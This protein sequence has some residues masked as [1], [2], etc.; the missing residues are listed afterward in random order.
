M[1]P[2]LR[3]GDEVLVDVRARVGVGVG[4]IV[5]SRHPHR[6]DVTWIKRVESLDDAG[7]LRLVGDSRE[8]TDSRTQ[9]AVARELIIGR[10]TSRL[11]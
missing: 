6:V 4:D 2:T 8:S 10:V 9:G 7:R 5:V 1:A 3:E 11:P